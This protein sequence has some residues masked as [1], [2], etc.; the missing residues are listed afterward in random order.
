MIFS[1]QNTNREIS[2]G[3]GL[4]YSQSIYRTKK[5]RIIPV[6]LILLKYGKFSIQGTSINYSIYSKGTK[7]FSAGIN[8]RPSGFKPDDGWYLNGMKKRNDQINITNT[9]ISRFKNYSLSLNAYLDLNNR[10]LPLSLSAGISKIKRYKTAILNSSL[11]IEY[12][13]RKRANLNYAVFDY[14]STSYREHYTL[15]DVIYP[16]LNISFTKMYEN[17]FLFTMINIKYLTDPIVKSPIIDRK[18]YLTIITGYSFK[19]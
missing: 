8:Y 4:I 2:L 13:N 15:R 11:N 19:I 1:Q 5:D 17:S 9:F 10:G 16:S 18:I 12:E 14:E 7:T 6:P 3:P